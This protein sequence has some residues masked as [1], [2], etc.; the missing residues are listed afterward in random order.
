MTI[1]EPRLLACE[2]HRA[3]RVL[4]ERVLT[5]S[6]IADAFL[7]DWLLHLEF[8]IKNAVLAVLHCAIRSV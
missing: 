3:A 1:A 7:L 6:S 5:A 2:Q 8:I 4:R